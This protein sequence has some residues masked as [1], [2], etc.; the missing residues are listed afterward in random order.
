MNGV[1][2]RKILL[3]EKDINSFV[4]INNSLSMNSKSIVVE[5]FLIETDAIIPWS[6]ILLNG[7]G[8]DLDHT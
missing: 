7:S 5:P 4:T 8:R 2:K 3:I 6:A 1:R